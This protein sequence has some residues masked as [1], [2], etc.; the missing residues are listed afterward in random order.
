MRKGLRTHASLIV[1]SGEVREVMHY[2]L[3]V[4]FG[5]NAVCPH[6]ALATVQQLAEEGLLEN[7]TRPEEAADQYVTAVKKGLLKTFS[8]MGISTIRSYFGAQIFEAVGLAHE[9][10]DRYF[11]GTASRVEGIGLEEIAA[12][13]RA[14]HRRGF[15]EHGSPAPLLDVGGQYNVR[16]GGENHLW[17]PEA[18]YKLQQAVRTDDYGLYREYA[19]L[20]NDR[21]RS[22]VTLRSLLRVQAGRGRA[23]GGG[24][25]GRVDRAAVRLQRHVV[26]LHLQGAHETIALAMNRLGARATPAKAA[27]TP[28]ATPPCPRARVCGAAVKQVA[29]GRFGVTTAYVMSA[30]TKSGYRH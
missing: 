22:R 7:P 18:I 3:L 21:S 26:R 14:L 17:S 5:A 27:K 12:E 23:A 2:A 13:A 15:P 6:L 25:A 28:P 19:A 29:S 10:V 4:G 24:R 8:R 30:L 11:T 9:V 16:V 1:E 20:I